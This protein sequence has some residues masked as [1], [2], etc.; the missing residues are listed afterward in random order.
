MRIYYAFN[1]VIMFTLI[2]NISFAEI[3]L[4]IEEQE[5]TILSDLFLLS[6]KIEEATVKIDTLEKNLNDNANQITKKEV[7]ISQALYNMNEQKKV[8]KSFLVFYQKKGVSSYFEMFMSSNN[9]SELL[10]KINVMKDFSK[11]MKDKITELENL[12][13]K[14]V[15]EKNSLINYKKQLLSDKENLEVILDENKHLSAELENKLASLDTERKQYEYML[16]EVNLKWEEAKNQLVLLSEKVLKIADSGNIPEDF[17]TLRLT[18]TGLEA[19][20]SEEAINKLLNQDGTPPYVLFDVSNDNILLKIESSQIEIKGYFE[21]VDQSTLLFVPIEGTYSDMPISAENISAV[22]D[23]HKI[24]IDLETLIG[25][26]KIE[27]IKIK[28]DKII[29]KIGMN[30]F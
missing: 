14:L 3:S 7:E 26:G 11:N 21:I 10:W 22:L 17:Y 1:W 27:S 24:A 28:D 16:E 19:A 30:T 13:Q 23:T 8:V 12:D 4:S 29:L 15:S 5:D 20:I 2:V 9:L 18:F 25:S 6:L